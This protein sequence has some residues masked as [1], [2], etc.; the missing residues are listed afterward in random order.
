MARRMRSSLDLLLQRTKWKLRH[1]FEVNE[2]FKKKRIN[3]ESVLCTMIKLK[4][5]V[6][7]D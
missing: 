6:V 4:N 5:R 1:F 3:T 7:Y 2:G